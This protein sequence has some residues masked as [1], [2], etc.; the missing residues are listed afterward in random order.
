MIYNACSI[1]VGASL[2]DAM[3]SYCESNQ[4]NNYNEDLIWEERNPIFGTARGQVTDDSELGISL[5]LGLLE[6]INK[7]GI[8]KKSVTNM[9][10]NFIAFYYLYWLCSNP[11]D[12][13]NT[14]RDAFYFEN[15]P[16]SLYDDINDGKVSKT[17]RDNSMKKNREKL[18]NGF[19]MRHTPLSVL[20]YYLNEKTSLIDFKNALETKQ[21]DKLFLTF[22]DMVSNEVYL[23][24]ANQECLVGT[25]VYNFLILC[26]LNLKDEH[27]DKFNLIDTVSILNLLK[28]FLEF[29]LRSSDNNVFYF[30]IGIHSILENLKAILKMDNFE[31][32][33]KESK[34]ILAISVH[35]SG[36]YLHAIDLIFFILRFFADFCGTDNIGTYS[37]IMKFICNKGGDTDT[38]CCIVGGIVGALCGFQNIEDFYV[39][40][41]LKFNAYD[42]K[43]DVI[44]PLIYSPIFMTLFGF[45][46]FSLV[47]KQVSEDREEKR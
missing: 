40:P 36:H 15:Y 7:Y 27:N 31:K 8:E 19:L 24:H 33:S 4:N 1:L 39:E 30:K 13:G 16:N 10:V 22:S 47:N 25:V 9:K 32:E 6:T 42:G 3:G 28:D 14:T 43:N 29:L 11:F 18:T 17:F 2:G 26:I 20:I 35:L 45:K 12:I 38:N 34:Y 44:R 5:A 37:K 46:L 23:T 41:H 21:F